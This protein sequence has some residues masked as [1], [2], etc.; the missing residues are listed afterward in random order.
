MPTL[1]LIAWFTPMLCAAM[2]L[3]GALRARHTGRRPF[4]P[5][6]RL[7]IIQITTVGNEETVNEIIR[8]IRGYRLDSP[9]KI[10]VVTE[11]WAA[12]TNYEG[13]DELIVVPEDFQCH[14]S[15][16]ARALEYSRRFR[17]ERRF[18]DFYV[19]V[20]FVDDDGVPTKS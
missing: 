18:N 14:A 5:L 1:I 7:L 20:L 4:P 8:R 9:H 11:P 16:K 10:W 19:K 12:S 15:Y 3:A 13:A 2:I 6:P 17:V